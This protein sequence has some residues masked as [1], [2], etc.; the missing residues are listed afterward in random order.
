MT[1]PD[2]EARL[3]AVCD[4]GIRL[5]AERH[6]SPLAKDV[7]SLSRHF[8]AEKGS[9]EAGYLRRP[10]ERR[11]YLGWFAPR[12]AAR[13]A[14][15]LRQLVEEGHLPPWE[16]PAVLDLGAGPLSGLLGAW[17][18][19]GALGEAVAVDLAAPALADGEQLF[20]SSGAVA[21]RLQ[22]RVASLQHPA[23]WQLRGG[24]DLILVANAIGEVGDPRRAIPARAA[25]LSAAASHLAPGG[26]LLVLEPGTRIHGQ[27]LMRLRDRLVEAGQL[28]VLA[29]CTG[30]KTCPL[31]AAHGS[32]CHA[33]ASWRPPP[34]VAA[35]A[36]E[37]GLK[38]TP[39]GYSYLL[40]GRDGGAPEGFRLVGGLMRA[41]GTERRYVCSAAGLLEWSARGAL[42]PQVSGAP[43]GRLLATCP[44]QVTTG[45][46]QGDATS[47]ERPR[48]SRARRGREAE[49]S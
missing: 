36:R 20:A 49:G 45:L 17:A 14:L 31:L 40:L 6:S 41:R 35:L 32:W 1:A 11:A 7:Q 24:L 21:T 18:A 15:L 16:R 30:A 23:D 42:P 43:R 28:R 2:F 26:R 10:G 8:G 4:A 29:P 19:F 48:S 25:V 47:A 5:A 44:P 27:A 13:V 12:N 33:E 3:R 9:R 22:T 46:A 38:A 39:L 34:S 37:S